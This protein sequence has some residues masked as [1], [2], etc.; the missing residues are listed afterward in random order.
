MGDLYKKSEALRREIKDWKVG[1]NESYVEFWN[2]SK[3]MATVSNDNA[4]GLRGSMLI[5]DEYRLVDEPVVNDILIPTLTAPRQPGYLE[6]PE[7]AHLTEESKEIFLSS[8]WYKHHWSYKRFK[9]ISIDMLKGK[10]AFACSIPFT[11]SLDH[12]LLTKKR[13]KKEME[14]ESMTEASFQMEYC[15]KFWGENDQSYFKMLEIEPCRTIENPFY[16]MDDLEYI[17]QKS[18]NKKIKSSLPKR[19]GEIRILSADIAVSQAKGSDNSVYALM[20]ILPNGG[21]WTRQV[22]HIESHQGMEAERQAIKIKR[23][24]AEFECDRMIIDT[25]GVG[26]TV[27]GYLQKVNVD[28]ERNEEYEAFTCYNEDKSV[29]KVSS[30]NSLPVVYSLIP[31]KDTN[32]ECAMLLKDAFIRE[33]IKLPVG[34]WKAR[35]LMIDKDEEFI[36]KSGEYQAKMLLPFVQT[37]AT[38]NELINLEFTLPGG[39][40]TLKEV[41]ASRKD[42]YSSLSYLNYLAAMIEQEEYKKRNYDDFD[43]FIALW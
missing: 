22:V 15:G 3:I 4:R 37:T 43:N 27:W 42:R 24:F 36:S 38:I 34:D 8:G 39:K 29:D 17:T 35:E 26:K 14:K 6:K 19:N 33:K 21:E 5:I 16:P 23:L 11:C 28:S 40:I 25:Q 31:S 18:K 13:I 9:E 41:G 20:R 2:G 32:H 30:Q 10:D 7:Y 1:A 12:G